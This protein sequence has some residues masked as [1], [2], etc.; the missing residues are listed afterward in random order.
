MDSPNFWLLV[1]GLTIEEE[2]AAILRLHHPRGRD[3]GEPIGRIGRCFFE[4]LEGSHGRS[5]EGSPQAVPGFGVFR[6]EPGEDFE[7]LGRFLELLNGDQRVAQQLPPSG[8]LPLELHVLLQ[9]WNRPRRISQLLL[10]GS[11]KKQ[12][13]CQ[14]RIGYY[15]GLELPSRFEV[16][17]SHV[18]RNS[19]IHLETRF[20]GQ[21]LHQILI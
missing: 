3:Q 5:L 6:L 11:N 17:A 2:G 19:Q 20:A 7:L 14:F 13:L 10:A 4:P 21:G 16:M 1:E 18:V 15:R 12:C 9:S 8:I